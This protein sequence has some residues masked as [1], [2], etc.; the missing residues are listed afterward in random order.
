MSK[1]E[2]LRARK[3][4]L[5]KQQIDLDKQIHI[6]EENELLAAR[7]EV[8]KKLEG[9]PDDHKNLILSMLS[10]DRSSCSDSKVTNGRWT[11]RDGDGYRCRKC[12]L[13]E[14]F[15]GE[16]GGDFDFS[17]DVVITKVTV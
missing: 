13:I 10:H 1:L 9:I 4:E 3:A 17:L 11:T 2:E 14:M 12:M 6:E 5:D 8:A 7:R 16:H 15:D